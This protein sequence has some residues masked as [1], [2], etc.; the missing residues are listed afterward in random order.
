[1]EIIKDASRRKLFLIIFRF[2]GS[3]VTIV[4]AFTIM[5]F[6]I[7]PTP[8]VHSFSVGSLNVTVSKEKYDLQKSNELMHGWDFPGDRKSLVI[9][10]LKSANLDIFSLQEVKPD[11][12]SDL[13]RS[14]GRG[15]IVAPG[16]VMRKS[17]ITKWFHNISQPIFV[18]K[19][20][21]T[22]LASDCYMLP[23]DS[24][25]PGASQGGR[26]RMVTWAKVRDLLTGEMYYVHN[27]HLASARSDEV[28]RIR[29]ARL[30]GEF[31]DRNRHEVAQTIVM[32]DFNALPSSDVHKIL[33]TS[34]KLIDSAKFAADVRGPLRT[35][36]AWGNA[37][38]NFRVD[39]VYADQKG[40]RRYE[41]LEGSPQGKYP[42]D[43]NLIKVTY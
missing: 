18:R 20:R 38:H 22:I 2:I 6:A 3:I 34:Y 33:S 43:H 39:Y 27:A 13:R 19:D 12:L 14:L 1:M 21:F 41:V 8:I 31:V 37:D 23:Q 7:K 15:Y 10:Q 30:I 24:G 29:S 36:N 11:Q 42:S 40:P 28:V 5:P 26:E 32:G 25:K 17:D 4:I 16:C 35:Y 9:A